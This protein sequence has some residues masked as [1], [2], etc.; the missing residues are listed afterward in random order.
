MARFGGALTTFGIGFI[1]TEVKLN[2]SITDL[3]TNIFI[4]LKVRT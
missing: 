4:L 1:I 2:L 3:I